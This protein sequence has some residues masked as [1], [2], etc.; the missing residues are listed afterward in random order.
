MP[1]DS[2]RTN[3]LRYSPRCINSISSSTRNDV[4]SSSS[5][6]VGKPQRRGDARCGCVDPSLQRDRQRLGHRHVGE[7]A[8]VLEAATESAREHGC[9][10]ESS[11][12]SS[13][14]STM[15]PDVERHEATDE[16]EH[17]GLAGAVRADHADDLARCRPRTT[18]RRRRGLPPNERADAGD[19]EE[20]RARVG[21]A[22][23]GW[24]WS[25]ATRWRRHDR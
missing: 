5:N 19:L 4:R 15:R 18:R 3:E 23:R 25:T 13:P 20:R 11:L 7:Q 10:R 8:G 21:D 17:R 14:S 24:L 1:V 9:W 2:S 12:M 22:G 6:T 16:I